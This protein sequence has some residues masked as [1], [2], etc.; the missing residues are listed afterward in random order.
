M[1]MEMIPFFME[2]DPREGPTVLSSMISTGA[3]SAPARKTMARSRASSVS[4]F[5]VMRA[6]PPEIFSCITGAE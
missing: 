6:S 4:K 5:P 3:G 2:S 1:P